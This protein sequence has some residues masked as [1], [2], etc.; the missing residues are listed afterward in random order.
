MLLRVLYRDSRDAGCSYDAF[1]GLYVGSRDPT[2]WQSGR[3][4]KFCVFI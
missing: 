4:H 3:T 1:A 2:E